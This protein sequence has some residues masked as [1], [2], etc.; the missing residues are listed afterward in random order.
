VTRRL[1]QVLAWL[2]LLAA[3]GSI[4]LAYA[5][6]GTWWHYLLHQSVGWGVGLGLAGAAMA[7]GTRRIPAVLAAVAGQLVSITPDLMFRYLRMPHER[8]MDLYL[9]HIALHTGPSPVVVALAVL[10]LGGWGWLA[11][12]A[13]RQRTGLALGAGSLVVLTVACLLAAPIPTRLDQY[14]RDSAAISR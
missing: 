6:R 2:G 4:A 8:S 10:L 11:A 3:E 14:P 1:L 9:G 12:A 13:G 5:N 7:L